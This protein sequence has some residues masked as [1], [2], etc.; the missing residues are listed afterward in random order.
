M[1][2]SDKTFIGADGRRTFAGLLETFAR[3][4]ERRMLDDSLRTLARFGT[5]GTCEDSDET[6]GASWPFERQGMVGWPRASFS[7]P[8]GRSGE[9]VKDS[10]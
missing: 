2:D 8:D 5:A 6:V 4:P 7:L 10:R 9:R 3:S 1:E